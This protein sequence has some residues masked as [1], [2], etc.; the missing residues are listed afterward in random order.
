MEINQL[1][2]TAQDALN[3]NTLDELAHG[4]VLAALESHNALA[5]LPLQTAIKAINYLQNAVLYTAYVNDYAIQRSGNP[6]DK[7][8]DETKFPREMA[9]LQTLSQNVQYSPAIMQW[10]EERLDQ[11]IHGA[12]MRQTILPQFKS[13]ASL[14]ADARC[15]LLKDFITSCVNALSPIQCEGLELSVSIDEQNASNSAV[16]RTQMVLTDEQT[17]HSAEVQ[18]SEKLFQG[19][20]MSA[21]LILAFHE[22]VHVAIAQCAVAQNQQK[23]TEAHPLYE[24]SIL[25][26]RIYEHDLKASPF[27]QSS[28][29]ADG[30]E[31]LVYGVQDRF[32]ERLTAS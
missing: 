18:F 31:A 7:V 21:A 6:N 29:R 10:M 24:D 30:E 22:S 23:I 27:I 28:Y 2:E 4:K 17:S 12:H 20:S 19:K 9:L 15:A 16:T 8:V 14:P 1:I 5:D 11:V 26:R 25:R 13:A 32:V 3:Q